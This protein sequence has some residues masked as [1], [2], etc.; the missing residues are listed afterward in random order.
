MMGWDSRPWNETAFFW[1][2]N[3]PEK[4]RDL[5]LRAKG[6]MDSTKTDGPQKNTII[7]CCW[8]EFGEGH[9]IEPTRGYGFSYT[10]V[11]REV[12]T[13]SPKEHSD[14]APE[15]VGRGPYDSWY[16]EARQAAPPGG[17]SSVTEWKGDQLAA[18]G[19]MMN[20]DGVGVRDGILR[21]VSTSSDPAFTSPAL[22]I[23]ASRFAKVVIEMRV[24]K[25]GGAQLFWTTSAMPHAN[26]PASAHV[27]TVADGEFH[28]CTFEVGKSE[29]WGGCLTG[30]RFDPAVME[31]VS[32]EIR[33]I[34]LE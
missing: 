5:C 20:V 22:K 9:Y 6:V 3:T 7:F 14:Y 31:G 34:W 2:D 30:M 26:E 32:I 21:A 13:D 28:P 29:Y 24:S 15:D 16:R 10:D 25:P 1:S 12:F 8:N 17:V 4:F 11:I 33:G 23:R 19:G 27:T 18:W